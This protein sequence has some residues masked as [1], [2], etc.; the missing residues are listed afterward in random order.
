[1]LDDTIFRQQFISKVFNVKFL[2]KTTSRLVLLNHHKTI[3][4]HYTFLQFDSDFWT[5]IGIRFSRFF[6]VTIGLCKN[7]N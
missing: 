4:L 1:M 3:I 7:N 5:E 2:I 6:I